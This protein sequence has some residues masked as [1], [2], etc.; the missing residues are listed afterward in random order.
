MLNAKYSQKQE[1]E[2]DDC[3]YD[4]LKANNCNPWGMVKAFEKFLNMEGN[5]KSSYMSKMFSSHPDTK[6]RIERMTKRAVA[7]GI[8]RPA[9]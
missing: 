8:E 7:D 5:S 9:E 4:F 3:G 6:D 1:K 2:A